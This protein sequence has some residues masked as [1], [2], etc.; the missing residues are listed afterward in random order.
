MALPQVSPGTW[1]AF[2]KYVYVGF[3]QNSGE[4]FRALALLFSA[5]NICAA[6]LF[7]NIL[8]I[9]SISSSF[10]PDEAQKL[11]PNYLQRFSVDSTS[12]QSYKSTTTDPYFIAVMLIEMSGQNCFIS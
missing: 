2:N 8:G 5:Y 6:I 9:I 4:P 11:G 10:D 3:K 7:Q 1:P 12:M